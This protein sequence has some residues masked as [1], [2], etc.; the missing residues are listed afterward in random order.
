MGNDVSLSIT[1]FVD[2]DGLC[3]FGVYAIDQHGTYKPIFGS[4]FVCPKP[5]SLLLGCYL[6]VIKQWQLKCSMLL[7]VSTVCGLAQLFD[8]VP[9]THTLG[10]TFVLFFYCHR[11]FINL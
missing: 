1:T 10:A 8:S 7:I 6:D 9:F 11:L 3:I 4:V 2:G 5:S